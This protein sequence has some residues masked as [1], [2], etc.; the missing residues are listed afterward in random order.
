M[1]FL[2]IDYCLMLLLSLLLLEAHA[3]RCAVVKALMLTL[4]YVQYPL[5]IVQCTVSIVHCTLYSVH[6]TVVIT[7]EL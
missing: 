5:Y 3:I 2:K 4:P 6:C 7:Q 1:N